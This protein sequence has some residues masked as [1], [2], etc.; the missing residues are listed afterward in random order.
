[1]RPVPIPAEVADPKWKKGASVRTQ[2]Y[3]T[4]EPDLKLAGLSLWALAREFPDSDDHWDRNG[5]DVAAIVEAPGAHV[6]I[7]GPYLRS[8]E[9]AA[10]REQI[11][12]LHVELKGSAKLNCIEPALNITITCDP[13]GHVEVVVDIT[14]NHLSQSHQ[15]VFAIDQSY[16]ATALSGCQRVLSRFPVETPLG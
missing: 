6:E 15:F 10:F 11:A 2:E 3:K 14:P 9:L 1:M 4:R 13:L 12:A 16:L 5:I 8:D 7:R